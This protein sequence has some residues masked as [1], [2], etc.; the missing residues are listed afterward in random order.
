MRLLITGA[1]GCL[2]SAIVELARGRH[3]TVAFDLVE[4]K[5]GDEIVTGS[6]TDRELVFS[7][8]KGCDAVIHTAGLHG[9]H[10]RTH[11]AADYLSV[12]VIGVNNLYEAMTAHGVK[13]MVQSS[14]MEVVCGRD[15]MAN[16]AAVLDE[17]STPRPDWIYPLSKHLAEQ[18]APY[19]FAHAGISTA[20]LRYM[21]M[22]HRSPREAGLGLL[23]RWVDRYDAAEAN[24]LAAEC[25]T[26]G[27]DV[28]HI[29]PLTPLTNRDICRSR[30][31]LEGVLE[32]HFPGSVALLTAHDIPLR[33]C[34][35]PVAAVDKAIRVLGWQH[36]TTFQGLLDSLAAESA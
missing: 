2:G 26:I 31:D 25:P 10:S 32:E 24:L 8:V 4:A 35:W 29:G 6:V 20:M 27:V 30:G 15:W 23:A 33:D 14:T 19:Y 34:L 17:L 18:L 1:A 28:F 9:A 5:A 12:N 21:T 16:G 7:A 13:R 3:Q 11:G 22:D 36:R